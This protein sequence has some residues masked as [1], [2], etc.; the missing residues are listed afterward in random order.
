MPLKQ[1]AQAVVAAVAAEC[2]GEQNKF[3]EL[4]DL[5]YSNQDVWAI[6]NPDALLVDL[7][8]QT[9]IDEDM[10]RECFNS[11]QALEHV[12]AD[13]YDSQGI[14]DTTPTFIVLQGEQ[15]TVIRGNQPLE[16]FISII[17]QL[18]EDSQSTNK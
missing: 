13:M 3:W 7:A 5:L 10:F 9:G 11:R 6:E 14:V 8:K 15:G 17:Q 18:I 12:L 16:D 2:A 1:H 4:H